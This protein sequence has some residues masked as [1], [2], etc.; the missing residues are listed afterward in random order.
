MSETLAQIAEGWIKEHSAHADLSDGG[1]ENPYWNRLLDLV[2]DRPE[3][4]WAV[5]LQIIDISDD[6][7]VI[8]NVSAGPLEDLL[9]FHGD[10]LIARIAEE[11]E[12]N[13]RLRFALGGVWRN[14]ISE[15]VWQIIEKLR[16]SK[17]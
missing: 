17:W 13:E 15:E 14:N 4:A 3:E 12:Q 9:A 1:R 16:S 6:S 5:V 11:A 8:E 7:K 10:M 2:L